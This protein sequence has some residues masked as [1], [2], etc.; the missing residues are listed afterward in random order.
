[1]SIM[2]AAQIVNCATAKLR[3]EENMGHTTTKRVRKTL[4][5]SCGSSIH[6]RH[7]RD[8][9]G[10]CP[11]CGEWLFQRNRLGRKLEPLDDETSSSAFDD[12]DEWEQA[13]NDEIA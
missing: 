9:I 11:E 6:F 12:S 1:L 2:P 13:L 8:N 7:G 10:I 3:K 4:C 5:P